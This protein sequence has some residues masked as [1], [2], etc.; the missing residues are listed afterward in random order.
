MDDRIRS[1]RSKRISTTNEQCVKVMCL[2][3]MEKSKADQSI[4]LSRRSSTNREKRLRYTILHFINL[5]HL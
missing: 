4:W 1:G 2:R 3:N 5:L